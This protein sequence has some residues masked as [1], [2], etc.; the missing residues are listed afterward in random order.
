MNF[1][2]LT[3]RGNKRLRNHLL[4]ALVSLVLTG[5]LDAVLFQFYPDSQRWIFRWSVATGYVAALL[6]AVTLSLGAWNILR[7]RVNPVSS[8]LRRDAGIWC[9]IFSLAH[10]GFG[11][12]VHL[13]RWAQYF[14]DD[15]G[16]L[17]TDAFGLA[18]YLGVL[19]TI[20]VLILVAT[21]NDVSLR[22]FKRE[23][24]KWIQRSNYIFVFL[25]V[26]HSFVYQFVEKRLMPYGFIFGV[27]ALW[28]LMI[29][30]AGFQK[31]RREMQTAAAVSQN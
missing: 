27:I 30:F 2:A 13:Q 25:V 10:V 23:R 15:S 18:N 31:R 28:I 21:S 11:L 24:W 12:N 19:A 5:L 20:I 14:I 16:K 6:L 7:G 8:D 1:S 4:I 29:Q 26:A 22:F 17:L 9:A 3:N